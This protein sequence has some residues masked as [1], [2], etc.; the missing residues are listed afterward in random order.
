MTKIR[1][2]HEPLWVKILLFFV[3]GI[4]LSVFIVLPLVTIFRE[5]LKS[6]I[7][8]Y[9]QTFTDP[10]VAAAIRLSLLTVLICVP[11][12]TFFGVFIAWLITKYEFPGKKILTTVI[13]LPFS[14]SPV[15]AGLLFIFMFGS[16][17]W[18]G[19]WLMDHDI[20]IV[21]AVP[22]IVL[23]T[24]FVSFPFVARELT[25]L[26]RELGKD[27]EEAAL[28]LGASGFQIFWK[29][30]LP[31]IKWG[32]LYGIILTNARALGEFGAVSVV[33]GFIRGV[34][35]TMPLYIDILYGEYMFRSAFAL[36]SLMTFLALVTII[37]K[38]VLEYYIAAQR[39]SMEVEIQS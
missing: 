24:L 30:T 10:G 38:A 19:T 6:G 5:A 27:D 37:A 33:S 21:F 35:T 2:I 3:S 34:T 9:L 13:D 1:T 4:F 32:L 11:I 8:L 26:M 7:S 31:N 36:A 39:K 23:A 25:P 18:F 22:G 12:N 17:G 15:I 29:V 16:F 14:I 20:R 28:T